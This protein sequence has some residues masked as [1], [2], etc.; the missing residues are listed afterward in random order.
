MYSVPSRVL[1]VLISGPALSACNTIKLNVAQVPRFT[2]QHSLLQETPL[3]TFQS[4]TEE[5][6]DVQ[7]S[8][9]SSTVF[10]TATAAGNVEIWDMATSTLHPVAQH[11]FEGQKL[12]CMLFSQESP[13]VVAGSSAGGVA[14]LRLI[15]GLA[16]EQEPDAQVKRLEDAMRANIVSTQPL[17]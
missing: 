8:P 11:G 14:V 9:R 16:A 15:D 2:L 6:N 5:V 10:G 7:W 3:L 12:S 1:L 4:T 13:V 17:D